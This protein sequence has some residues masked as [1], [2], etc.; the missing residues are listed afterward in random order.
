MRND[1]IRYVSGTHPCWRFR[2]CTKPLTHII[3]LRPA[4]FGR[5]PHCFF[6]KYH[7]F[8]PTKHSTK[9]DLPFCLH[10]ISISPSIPHIVFCC[11]L[12][13]S[14]RPPATSPALVG[15]L[16]RAKQRLNPTSA[17][18][19]QLHLLYRTMIEGGTCR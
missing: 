5:G 15:H 11:L 10:I 2:P 1:D 4:I 12:S 3:P 19:S 14:E 7:S 18:I 6:W 16:F 13:R 8:T 9:N 17:A